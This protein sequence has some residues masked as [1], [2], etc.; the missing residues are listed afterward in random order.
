[1]SAFSDY[2][3]TEIFDHVFR[4][5]AYVPVATVYL[6]LHSA[7]PGETGG[8]EI[9]TAGYA[10]QACAFA[11]AS[12]RATSNSALETFGPYTADPPN[13]THWGIY[14]ASTNGNLLAYGALASPSNVTTGDGHVIAIGAI[15]LALGQLSASPLADI[16]TYLANKILDFVFRNQAFSS[17]TGLVAALY[18]ANPDIDDGGDELSVSAQSDGYARQSIAFD[19]PSDGVGT[20]TAAVT[21]GPAGEN[22]E[23]VTHMAIK[24]GSDNLL[25]FG[26]VT[27]FS[28]TTGQSRQWAAGEIAA[29]IA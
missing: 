26:A 15:D 29:Q 7:S 25:V 28:L 11:A 18:I 19:A 16:S 20:N 3:E 21:F 23:A 1:M 22:W 17:P 24:D 14:D 2:L 8:N 6:S 10:R 13:V 5:A 12:S 9:T 4:G 27:S